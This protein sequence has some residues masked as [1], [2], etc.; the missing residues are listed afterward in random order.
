MNRGTAEIGK[1]RV[2]QRDDCLGKVSLSVRG[3]CGVTRTSEI[4][5]RESCQFLPPFISN[6]GRVT[7]FVFI[8]KNYSDRIKLITG[9]K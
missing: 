6:L 4:H 1:V 7:T 8:H 5:S 9:A 2:L 3:L